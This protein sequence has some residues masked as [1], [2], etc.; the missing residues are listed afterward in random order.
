MRITIVLSLL[1]AAVFAATIFLSPGETTDDVTPIRVVRGRE[2]RTMAATEQRRAGDLALMPVKNTSHV[3]VPPLAEGAIKPPAWLEDRSVSTPDVLQERL[4]G[5][6]VDQAWSSDAQAR[7]QNAAADA[8]LRADSVSSS[9]AC[10]K[11]VCIFS[12]E[13]VD[14][15]GNAQPDEIIFGDQ[16]R[17]AISSFGLLGGP[18]MVEPTTTGHRIVSFYL[19]GDR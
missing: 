5:E 19:R 9:I 11:T 3:G 8:G 16:L 15:M 17:S 7:I 10:H 12:V 13:T 2:E 14:R 4:A 6:S 1:V 18:Q